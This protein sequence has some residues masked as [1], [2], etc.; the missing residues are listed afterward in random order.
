MQSKAKDVT[1]YLLEAEPERQE[2]LAKLRELCRE[3]LTGYEEGMDY[4]MPCYKKD[5]TT[6]VGFA[7]QKNYISLYILKVDVVEQNRAALK[8]LSVGKGCIRYSNP[9]KMDMEVIRKLL[10]DTVR[11]NDIPC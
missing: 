11:S 6:E 4:G 2:Y 7:S 5:G 3:V 10:S 8:G 9:K 1:G